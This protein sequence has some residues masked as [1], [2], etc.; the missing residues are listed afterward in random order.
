[1][2][3]LRR[4]ATVS[5]VLLA[6]LVLGGCSLES[7]F[8]SALQGAFD[9]MW[10]NAALK[11]ELEQESEK[12]LKKSLN[13]WLTGMVVYESWFGDAYIHHVKWVDV[14]LG[15]NAPQIQVDSAAFSETASHYV[16]NL[17]WKAAWNPGTKGKVRFE[18]DIRA[19]HGF[20]DHTITV[21]A[22]EAEALGNTLVGI[23]KSL[24]GTGFVS[25]LVAESK[26]DLKAK[27]AGWFWTI[28]QSKKVKSMINDSLVKYVVGQSFQKVFGPIL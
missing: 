24:S 12:K 6:V 13:D 22:I 21:H 28:D 9:A 10:S 16:L 25:V 27:A 18:L 19:W 15:Q 26:V 1:M 4:G 14:N 3:I 8:Q 11:K 17:S 23:P 20:P 5:V 7:V 2:A